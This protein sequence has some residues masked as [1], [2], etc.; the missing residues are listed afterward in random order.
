MLTQKPKTPEANPAFQELLEAAPQDSLVSQL[1]ALEGQAQPVHDSVLPRRE[2]VGLADIK[3]RSERRFGLS[4]V[5][6]GIRRVVSPAVREA[7]R[8]GGPVEA[9]IDQPATLAEPVSGVNQGP[10]DLSSPTPPLD[11]EFTPPPSLPH[12]TN[13]SI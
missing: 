7:L 2:L 9:I 5:E 1:V 8:P 3:Q 13:Q 11:A 10:I 4:R 12:G 6:L